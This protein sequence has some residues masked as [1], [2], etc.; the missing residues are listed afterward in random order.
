M[1]KELEKDNSVVLDATNASKKKRQIFIKIAK[2]RKIPVKVV[3]ITTSMKESMNQNKQRDVKVPDMAFFNYKKNFE[4]PSK[5]EE[6][7][8]R[9]TRKS[10]VA[11]KDIKKGDKFTKDNISVKRPGT[12]ISAM[13]WYTVLGTKSLKDYKADD[14]I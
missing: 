13:K 3:H 14:L 1:I 6:K 12:G 11:I 9:I 8:K 7:N 2:E 4:K 5:S 10:I